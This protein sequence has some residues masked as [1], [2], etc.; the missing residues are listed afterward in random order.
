[1]PEE[2]TIQTVKAAIAVLDKESES[3]Q[4]Y[5]GALDAFRAANEAFSIEAE[6]Y[7]KETGGNLLEAGAPLA[8]T[9]IAIFYDIKSLGMD[10]LEDSEVYGFWTGCKT[11]WGNSIPN[12]PRLKKT[13]AGKM[14]TWDDKGIMKNIL[15]PAFTKAIASL[16]KDCDAKDI[17]KAAA[18]LISEDDLQKCYSNFKSERN[19]IQKDGT[20][21]TVKTKPAKERILAESGQ[22]REWNQMLNVMVSE[23]VI[24]RTNILKGKKKK[25][26]SGNMVAQKGAKYVYNL[27]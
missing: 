16:G 26:E 15:L 10:G 19:E 25:D 5:Q 9:K 17:R 4:R 24:T 14:E 3:L 11:A 21:K 12:D 2:I 18:E 7:K 22:P 13:K 23:N 1:M 8:D 20:S 27:A 6:R